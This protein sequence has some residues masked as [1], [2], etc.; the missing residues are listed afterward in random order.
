MTTDLN[1]ESILPSY[2]FTPTVATKA[3][4][5]DAFTYSTATP[6]DDDT[7]TITVDG[8]A[9][10]IS[11]ETSAVDSSP[12]SNTISVLVTSV[13]DSRNRTREA[14]NGHNAAYIVYGAGTDDQ[15]GIDGVSA[16]NGSTGTSLKLQSEDAGVSTIE[17]AG[18]ATNVTVSGTT[19]A[20][21][22]A[23]G[24]VMNIDIADLS[25]A[26]NPLTSSE[27]AATTGDYR[28]VLFHLVEKYQDYLA[29]NEQ[30]TAI[31]ITAG[32]TGYAVGDVVNFSGGSADVTAVATVSEIDNN[33][34]SGAG[35]VTGINISNAGKGYISAPTA[36]ITSTNGANCTIVPVI[37]DRVPTNLSISR[38]GLT[39][40]TETNT[41]QRTFGVTFGFEATSLDIKSE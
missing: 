21:G 31:T 37:S 20:S 26:Q 36:T 14:I 12:P 10:T 24:G 19:S 16:L 1:I 8:T 22:T 30:V 25:L 18:S 6:A 17:I 5:D 4:I 28:K 40:D 35:A 29:T 38:G 23:A 13:A 33:S 32:G 39:E 27:A 41:L 11:Y 9:F 2:G 3:I 15:Q 7:I 34:G